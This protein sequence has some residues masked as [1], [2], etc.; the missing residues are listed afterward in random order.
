MNFSISSAGQNALFTE[1]WLE[2]FGVVEVIKEKV[3]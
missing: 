3:G 1:I 2:T